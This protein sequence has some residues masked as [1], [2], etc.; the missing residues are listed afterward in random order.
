MWAL[1]LSLLVHAAGWGGYELGQKEGWW[2]QLRVYT[3]KLFPHRPAP[4]P[5]QPVQPATQ[6]ELA[7]VQ[8]ADPDAVAPPKPKFYANNN[9]HAAN[10]KE[11]QNNL[12]NPKL[13]GHQTDAPKTETARV[14]KISKAP[15]EPKQAQPPQP[16]QPQTQPVQPQPIVARGNE[17][18]G[19]PQEE[20]QHPQQPQPARPRT[21]KE[22]FARNP[23]SIA[24]LQMR[25]DGGTRRVALR[26]TFD[27]EETAFGDYDAEFVQAVEQKWYDLLDS[28]NFAGD[29]T[30]VV[31]LHFHL[32]YDGTI[33]ELTA[34]KTTV[35]TLYTFLC[36]RALTEP[37]PFARWPEDMRRLVGGNFRDM[38]FTFYYY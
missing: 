10:L 7:F 37:A 13:N 33:T 11:D 18:Q 32:N 8:V 34:P 31:V 38:T 14:T 19:H 20:Q 28:Q 3:W 27:A 15:T 30:G 24:G 36:E 21:L 5:A 17:T 25:Q 4:P 1:V 23:N 35:D 16:P 6:P 29:R 12:E 2:D 9:S 22:Y 26:P